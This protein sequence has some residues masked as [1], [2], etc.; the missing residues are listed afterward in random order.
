MIEIR[1]TEWD[2]SDGMVGRDRRIYVPNMATLRELQSSL[3][4]ELMANVSP[5]DFIP[6]SLADE[7]GMSLDEFKEGTV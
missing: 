2:F 1:F 6:D 5:R 4:I 7:H 3:D